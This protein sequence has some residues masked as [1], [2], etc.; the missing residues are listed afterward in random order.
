MGYYINPTNMRK[1]QWLVENNGCIYASPPPV[2]RDG[3]L[4]AVCLVNNGAFNAAGVAYN[5][6]EFDTFAAEDGREKVWFMVNIDKLCEV[7]VIRRE[8]L[9]GE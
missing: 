6:R 7:L 4:L 1:E 9:L 8:E 3:E 2:F 5:Q